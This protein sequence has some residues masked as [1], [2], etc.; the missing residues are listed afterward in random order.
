MAYFEI[1][2]A[3]VIYKIHREKFWNFKMEMVLTSVDLWNIIE[4]SEKAPPSNVDPKVLKDYQR[5]AKKAISIIGLNWQDNQLAHIK[6][7]K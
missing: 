7:C 6:N 2:A 3:I 5:H 1:E 4:G